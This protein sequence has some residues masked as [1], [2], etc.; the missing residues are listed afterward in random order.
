[1]TH[2]LVGWKLICLILNPLQHLQGIGIIDPILLMREGPKVYKGSVASVKLFCLV[3]REQELIPR[4]VCLQNPAHELTLKIHC[5]LGAMQ[6][7]LQ[8][9]S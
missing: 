4:S 3:N 2:Y 5:V 1:M 8:L 9:V 7:A 6:S